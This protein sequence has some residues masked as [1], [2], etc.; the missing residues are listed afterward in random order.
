MEADTQNK[1]RENV[2]MFED[3]KQI[4]IKYGHKVKNLQ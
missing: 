3:E 2:G 4:R 1:Q